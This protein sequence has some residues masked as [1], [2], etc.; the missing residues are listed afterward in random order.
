LLTKE[1]TRRG[2]PAP[3]GGKARGLAITHWVG[4]LGAVVAEVSMNGK[5]PKVHRVVGAVDCGTVVNSDIIVHW[6][7]ARRSSACQPR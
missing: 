7:R 5:M 1:S 6:D 4:S 2:G 3:G